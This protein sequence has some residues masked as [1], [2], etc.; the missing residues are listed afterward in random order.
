MLNGFEF[1]LSLWL[2]SSGFLGLIFL[3]VWAT[4]SMRENRAVVRGLGLV[5]LQVRLPNQVATPDEAVQKLDE[6]F[7]L[8]HGLFRERSTWERL[9]QGSPVISFEWR[10]QDKKIEF[11]LHIPRSWEESVRRHLYGPLPEAEVKNIGTVSFFGSKK[12]VEIGEIKHSVNSFFPLVNMHQPEWDPEGLQNLLEASEAGEIIFQMTLTAETDAFNAQ[13]L[14]KVLRGVSAD[15]AAQAR[16]KASHLQFLAN[17]RFLVT[18]ET[19][20]KAQKMYNRAFEA[21][22]CAAGSSELL[23]S[24]R[25]YPEKLLFDFAYRNFDPSN[26]IRIGAGEVRLMWPLGLLSLESSRGSTDS[27][28]QESFSVEEAYKRMAPARPFHFYT[29]GGTGTGKTTLMADMALQDIRSGEGVVVIDPHGDLSERVLREIPQERLEDVVYFNPAEKQHRLRFNLL[30]SGPDR[31]KHMLVQ[32]ILGIFEKMFPQ[33]LVGPVFEHNMRHIFL[34]LMADE[35]RPGTLVD[36]P[37]MLTDESFAKKY[38]DKLEDPLV[39]DFWHKERELLSQFHKSESLQYLISKLGRFIEDPVMR[40]VM[41]SAHSSISFRDVIEK[42]QIFIANLGKGKLGEMNAQLLGLILMVKMK[43]AAFQQEAQEDQVNE[44]YAYLDEFHN[45]ITS[46]FGEILSESRKFGLR[47]HLAHQF[48]NQLDKTT[49]QSVFNNVGT[50]ATFRVGLEDA[51]T[52]APVFGKTIEPDDLLALN[53]YQAFVKSI[54]ADSK[55]Q[56]FRVRTEPLSKQD[57]AVATT[58]KRLSRL[59]F[60]LSSDETVPVS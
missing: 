15:R 14:R 23:R 13:N 35:E 2:V 32:D 48:L 51:Q 16:S 18:A 4:V 44:L 57:A 20:T 19:K 52:L 17:M 9:T 50:L 11:Y 24:N 3:V 25:E 58:V 21:F 47:L 28:G 12:A 38:I 5:T 54:D 26:S 40:E 33:E 37:K 36:V 49:R 60:N 29:I 27:S 7:N 30:E 34:T 22:A 8:M 53:N 46:G 1:A 45:F 59:R 6:F 56:V 39:Q 41:N 10:I 43:M 55:S 42:K 31:Q